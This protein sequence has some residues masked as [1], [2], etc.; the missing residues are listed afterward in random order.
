MYTI[1][2]VLK[3]PLMV[4][5]KK[6]NSSYRE[7]GEYIPGGVLRAAYARALT[8]RCPCGQK[9]YW[10][11]YKAQG[12]CEDC[13][14]RNICRNFSQVSFPALYPLGAAPYLM[15]A[16]EKKYKNQGE[17]Y[18]IDILIS[19]LTRGGKEKEEAAWERPEGFRKQG[20]QVKL[21]HSAVTRTAIDYR[22]NAAKE[23]SLYTQNVVTEKYEDENGDF[24]EVVFQGEIRLTQEEAA[25]LAGIKI[26]HIGADITKG[27]GI[28]HMTF[29]EGAQEDTVE[30]LEDRVRKFNSGIGGENRFVVLDLITDAYL[31]LEKIGGDSLS[32]TQFTDR[33]ML[34]FLEERIGLPT[35]RYRLIKVFK[36]QEILRGYD[37]SKSTEKEMRRQGRLVVKA[38]AVF[39]YQVPAGEIDAEELL[40]LEEGGIGEQIKHGFGKIR[41]CDDFHIRYDV[42][43]GGSGNG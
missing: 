26:L 41:V 30:K 35:G 3:S 27:F 38:G 39:V 2:A 9:N 17:E 25:E 23:G 4:G 37:T 11:E 5:G 33:Q 12:A 36:Q 43:K 15:T 29:A 42:L 22:R 34:E 40:E 21:I 7:S 13:G 6:L 18:L 28:C 14:Y 16:R 10:L 31:G 32:Q 20:R 24:A 8:E 1:K 19:R